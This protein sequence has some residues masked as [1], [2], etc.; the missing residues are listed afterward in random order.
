[1]PDERMSRNSL[2][3]P[4]IRRDHDLD[5][6]AENRRGFIKKFD[7]EILYKLSSALDIN[8]DAVLTVNSVPTMWARASLFESIFLKKNDERNK[9]DKVLIGEWRGLL[10]LL[11]L[12]ETLLQ[13]I[14]FKQIN[15]QEDDDLSNYKGLLPKRVLSSDSTWERIHIIKLNGETIG[16]TSPSMLV[17]TAADYE[18]VLSEVEWFDGNRLVDPSPVLSDSS[19][20][21]LAYWL[22]KLKISIMNHGYIDTGNIVFKQLV[23]DIEC[24]INDLGYSTAINKK[25]LKMVN[26]DS[27]P[28]QYGRAH[29]DMMGG[30]FEY[31]S[32]PVKLKLLKEDPSDIVLVNHNHS[33]EKI[34]LFSDTMF[35]R[36]DGHVT[37]LGATTLNLVK[38]VGNKMNS[39]G[40]VPLPSGME[41]HRAEEWLFMDQIYLVKRDRM[42]EEYQNDYDK[43]GLT[44]LHEGN[45]EKCY[46]LMPIHEHVLD[47]LEID[48]IQE[49]IQVS[50]DNI[51]N[52][53]II[54]VELEV[55]LSG[56]RHV[57]SKVYESQQVHS[58]EN[59]PLTSIWPG[60]DLGESWNRYYFYSNRVY[61]NSEGDD[62]SLSPREHSVVEPF[63]H[64]VEGSKE[65]QLKI[66]VTTD[67]PQSLVAS[68]NGMHIGLVKMVKPLG[69][70]V[71]KNKGVKCS[72]GID[73][74]T[75]SSTIFYT[76]GEM[77]KPE[78]LKLPQRS[79]AATNLLR[80]EQVFWDDFIPYDSVRPELATIDRYFHTKFRYLSEKPSNCILD[81]NIFYEFTPIGSRNLT[82]GGIASDLKWSGDGTVNAYCTKTFLEQ[83]V[84]QALGELS[85]LGFKAEDIDWNFS[86]P[87]AFSNQQR[88][89]FMRN[90]QTVVKK[91]YDE[92]VNKTI[93]GKKRIT[94]M[95]ESV[96]SA[97]YFLNSGSELQ[98]N[99]VGGFVSSDIGAGTTDI[100]FW[101]N[102]D[103]NDGTYL[104]QTS[105]KYAGRDLFINPL[106]EHPHRNMILERMN[107]NACLPEDD[108][109]ELSVED[110]EF[111]LSNHK[112]AYTNLADVGE[113]DEIKNFVETVSF[114]MAGIFYYIGLILKKMKAENKI[115]KFHSNI[116]FGGNGSNVLNWLNN[117]SVFETDCMRAQLFE[118]IVQH[119]SELENMVTINMSKVPK[120]E[121]AG[122]M[123]V[124]ANKIKHDE[125]LESSEIIIGEK[126]IL[127]ND[128]EI[129]WSENINDILHTTKVSD[130]S[131]DNVKSFVDIY[132]RSYSE[133]YE[134]RGEV[135]NFDWEMESLL[136]DATKT[137]FNEFKN[138]QEAN[139][140]LFLKAVEILVKGSGTKNLINIGRDY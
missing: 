98:T 99:L 120:A 91:V 92:I 85:I 109:A 51:N 110:I 10:A 124:P 89:R 86:Y 87:T 53:N 11:A 45:E 49:H 36:K 22:T 59:T 29:V 65:Q 17:C 104:Y 69:R 101:Q 140:S 83:I 32:M 33:N 56:G 30:I 138:M 38:Q 28:N 130:L 14:E 23:E 115:T 106:L 68:V 27:D 77:K 55:Q 24:F 79:N 1:M 93:D 88:E 12:R 129:H 54:K 19:K 5:L 57:F 133:I 76:A 70:N 84:L 7:R 35:N 3:L 80:Q 42:H 62:F 75:S 125:A 94:F 64:Y 74:G 25:E 135:I 72:V 95:T 102:A 46:M 107:M 126:L 96:A 44:W 131:L 116:Y 132:N 52:K 121:A 6:R 119:A 40:S 63:V 26:M 66:H 82:Y 78:L 73:F 100:S 97:R 58:F 67:Y 71:T 50:T 8:G 18:G 137:N 34:M 81:G 15:F 111:G 118:R 127:D 123:V 134:Y 117:G 13:D 21:Q 37:V 20:N 128:S 41:L 16:F 136:K 43:I 31:I 61:I 2:W 113:L 108:S 112:D 122:G 90:C 114:G 105:I 9:N 60:Y 139:S 39:I 47:Y 48:Q 103:G 4:K